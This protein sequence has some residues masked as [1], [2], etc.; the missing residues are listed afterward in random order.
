MNQEEPTNGVGRVRD[1]I[2]QR[3]TM[4]LASQRSMYRQ[5]VPRASSIGMCGR[6]IFYQI[7]EEQNP[8]DDHLLERFHRGSEIET[9]VIRRLLG[10]GLTVI[11]TQKTFAIEKEIGGK[12]QVVVTGHVDGILALQIMEGAGTPTVHLAERN[13][14]F[15]IKSL[16]PNVWG[17]IE[18]F[19]DFDRMGS[20][21]TKYVDQLL[22]YLFAN[23]EVL[24]DDPIG[25]L[26]LDDCLGHL[27]IVGTHLWEHTERCE[28]ALRKAEAATAAKLGAGE[29]PDFI[30]DPEV[31]RG[32]WARAAG[33]CFPPM[34]FEAPE[35]LPDGEEIG[36]MLDRLAEIEDDVD[37]GVA[38]REE[39]KAIGKKFRTDPGTTDR[40]AGPYII[41]AKVGETTTYPGIPK[42]IKAPYAIKGTR[43][44]VSWE[45][46]EA[47][48]EVPSGDKT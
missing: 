35:V 30:D 25:I 40:L 39:V 15:D 38:I 8:P 11:D 31:C 2:E 1:A 34:K 26:I 6:E 20:F 13:V 23:A 44:V 43:T 4:D 46:L 12:N 7:T 3:L 22:L 36:A 37:E 42:E 32:C 14:V 18:R 27:K 29:I 16:H 33:H 10:V 45:R 24:G 47:V 9:I 48:E 17:R 19:E 21:W 28:S 5:H 41:R